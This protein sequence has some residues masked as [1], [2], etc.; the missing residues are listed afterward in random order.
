[1]QTN[2]SGSSRAGG[3][4]TTLSIALLGFLLIAAVTMLSYQHLNP[5]IERDLTARVATALQPASGSDFS[6]DGQDV[7]LTGTVATAK[8]K[9]AAEKSAAEVYGVSRVIN[10]LTV[11]GEEGE[12][13]SQMADKDTV[14]ASADNTDIQ[15]SIEQ[16]SA[17]PLADEQPLIVDDTVKTISPTL[18]VAVREGKVSTQGIVS[19]NDTITCMD[20]RHAVN[21]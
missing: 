19:D 8:L 14:T 6:I 11:A 21:D 20:K 17:T 12:I 10:N 18:T 13:A 2:S 7:I 1:M 3:V 16:L 15:S 4:G 5:E 9:E